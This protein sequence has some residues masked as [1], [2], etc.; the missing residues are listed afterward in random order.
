MTGREI[1]SIDK[2]IDI[3]NTCIK[4]IEKQIEMQKSQVED[5][6]GTEAW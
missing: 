2:Q 1:K 6:A 4:S 3:Q 5:A